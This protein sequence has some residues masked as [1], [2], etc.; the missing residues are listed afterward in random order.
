VAVEAAVR[1]VCFFSS[2]TGKRLFYTMIQNVLL[3]DF[4][5]FLLVFG[6]STSTAPQLKVGLIATM[7]DL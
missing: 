1:A 6:G 5:K 4:R 2:Q 7:A 3:L